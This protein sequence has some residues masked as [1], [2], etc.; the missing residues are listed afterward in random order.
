[1]GQRSRR[2]E[3]HRQG[4]GP[5]GEGR[6]TGQSPQGTRKLY[7][8]QLVEAW[9][10]GRHHPC[11]SLAGRVRR[12]VART[13]LTGGWGGDVPRE[14]APILPTPTTRQGPDEALGWGRG[15]GTWESHGHQDED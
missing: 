2:G 10:N 5:K 14:R 9:R 1:M 15:V 11:P 13:V 7:T 6:E 4:E 8:M 12:K 3:S